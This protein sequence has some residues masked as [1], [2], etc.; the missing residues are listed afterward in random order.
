MSVQKEIDIEIMERHQYILS[1]YKREFDEGYL[2][3]CIMFNYA[4]KNKKNLD[5][6][7]ITPRC[8]GGKDDKENLI[9]VTK[10]HHTELHNLILKSD[11]SDVERSNLE[12]AYLK[13]RGKLK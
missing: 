1:T 6:H 5:V 7:H 8:C 3:F 12:Y 13:R 2:K 10:K 4:D 11:L 9:V